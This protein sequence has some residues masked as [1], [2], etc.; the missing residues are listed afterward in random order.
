[1]PTSAADTI[2][3]RR[4]IDSTGSADWWPAES[5]NADCYACENSMNGEEGPLYVAAVDSKLGKIFV[6]Y[7]FNL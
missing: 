3:V 2:Q 7:Y 1:L 5:S 6:R 4:Q